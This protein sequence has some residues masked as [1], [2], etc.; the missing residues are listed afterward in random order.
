MHNLKIWQKFVLVFIGISCIIGLTV[1][2]VKTTINVNKKLTEDSMK[3]E[4][5]A[6]S[7]YYVSK[8]TSNPIQ[9]EP[10]NFSKIEQVVFEN[11]NK[12]ITENIVKEGYQLNFTQYMLDRW[13]TTEFEAVDSGG[14]APN[15]DLT[16]VNVDTTEYSEEWYAKVA[17]LEASLDLEETLPYDNRLT[18]QG[19][20]YF[21][22]IEDLDVS[23]GVDW[24]TYNKQQV[25]IRKRDVP[26]TSTT[27]PKELSKQFTFIELLSNNN[28]ISTVYTSLDNTVKLTIKWYVKGGKIYDV[29]F[30]YTYST[31][32]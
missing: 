5:Y 10:S 1:F 3:Q 27:A 14:D 8:Y 22:A 15:Q 20:E 16:G 6:L 26:L 4:V 7:S 24:V 21:I 13:G 28:M 18:K 25:E 32:F 9:I 31:H 12:E 29:S 2:I 19:D 23:K 30:D 17:E 11:I